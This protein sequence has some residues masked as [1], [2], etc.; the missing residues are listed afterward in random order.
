MTKGPQTNMIRSMS[1]HILEESTGLELASMNGRWVDAVTHIG[2]ILE[3]SMRM[4]HALAGVGESD[5]VSKYCKQCISQCEEIL[6][7]IGVDPS[8]VKPPSP[9]QA[10]EE[11]EAGSVASE[12]Q[13]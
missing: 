1:L 6:A 13:I 12:P 10:I 4:S 2:N 5:G 9:E 8:L 11:D 7:S 3:Y